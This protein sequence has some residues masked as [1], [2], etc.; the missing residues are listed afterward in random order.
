MVRPHKGAVAAALAA[1]ALVLGTT[2]AAAPA[3]A[4]TVRLGGFFDTCYPWNDSE[5]GGGWCNG[6]G[7][8]W[9]YQ[10]TAF[11]ENSAGQSWGTSGV[12]RWAGDRRGSYAYCSTQHGRFVYGELNV[13]QN[14]VLQYYFDE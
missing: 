13:Y 12:A 4:A 5:T 11:C 9:T 3:S 1:A 14:G 7:P 10:A 8:D 6:Q 2:A